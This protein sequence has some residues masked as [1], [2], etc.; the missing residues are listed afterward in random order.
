[1][2]YVDGHIQVVNLMGLILESMATVMKVYLVCKRM[3]IGETDTGSEHAGV[4]VPMIYFN[5]I[6]RNFPNIDK[7]HDHTSYFHIFMFIGPVLNRYFL[8]MT[9]QYCY[10]A[11][12]NRFDCKRAS[13][14]FEGAIYVTAH[15]DGHAL[16]R[17]CISDK[18]HSDTHL[19]FWNPDGVALSNDPNIRQVC[20]PS[21]K[22]R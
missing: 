2:N 14:D 1:M 3:S 5:C 13:N 15:G 6:S 9:G 17:G 4:V 12:K 22:G 19:I 8:S 7:Y 10:S 21:S 16:P 20:N 18:S 11:V